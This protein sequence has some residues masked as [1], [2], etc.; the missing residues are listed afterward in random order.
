MKKLLILFTLFFLIGCEKDSEATNV[1]TEYFKQIYN[2]TNYAE[3]VNEDQ[4][5]DQGSK[6]LEDIIKPF[7]TTNSV[8]FTITNQMPPT[9]SIVSN[10][11]EFEFASVEYY[12][13]ESSSS[14]TDK[15]YNYTL[16]I[17]T[18]SPSG[19]KSVESFKGVLNITLVDGE[20]KI[21]RDRLT[22]YNLELISK[23]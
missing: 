5:N 16:T 6:I 7:S 2:S 21:E 4:S 3:L 12:S 20:W 8:D 17:N 9:T 18:T 11:F 1:S 19:E 13:L 15:Y 14:E 10:G 23:H 22:A